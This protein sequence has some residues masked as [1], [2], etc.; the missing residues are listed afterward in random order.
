MK[1]RG[2]YVS[3]KYTDNNAGVKVG[4]SEGRQDKDGFIYVKWYI[5]YNPETKISKYHL[6]K[7]HIDSLELL[8]KS[9]IFEGLE[10]LRRTMIR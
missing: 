4:V 8:D 7:V 5:K 3:F 9:N 10:N 6:D 1:N 2:D